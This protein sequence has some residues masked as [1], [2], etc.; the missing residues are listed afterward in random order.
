M[1]KHKQQQQQQQQGQQQENE[2]TIVSL[3]E[4]FFFYDSLV[5]R[6][7]IDENK[8]PVARVTGSHKHS[9]IFGAISLEGKQL[10]TV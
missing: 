6:V 7:W 3:D 8:R 2:F 10:F 1:D 4:S 9:C 5:R